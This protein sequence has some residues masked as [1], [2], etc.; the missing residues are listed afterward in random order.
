M[1]SCKIL[2]GNRVLLLIFFLLVFEGSR[3]ETTFLKEEK[4]H[5]DLNRV[6]PEA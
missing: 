2:G 1:D 6:K 4:E 3:A 5:R